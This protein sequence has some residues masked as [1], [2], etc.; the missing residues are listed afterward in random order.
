M[1]TA[2]IRALPPIAWRD[3]Y[4]EIVETQD[5]NVL[6]VEKDRR[7]GLVCAESGEAITGLIYDNIFK[8]RLPKVLYVELEEKYG[9]IS[10]DGQIIVKPTYD[11]IQ[12]NKDQNVFIATVTAKGETLEFEITLTE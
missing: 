10:T 2:T 7:C 3:V 4:D 5:P 8:T 9:M 12:S 11:E 6:M 1:I